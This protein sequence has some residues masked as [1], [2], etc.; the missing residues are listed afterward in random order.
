MIM[1]PII[2][3]NPAITYS[4]LSNRRGRYFSPMNDQTMEVN[5]AG[6]GDLEEHTTNQW[7]KLWL[8]WMSLLAVC[9]ACV[10]FAWVKFPENSHHLLKDT[11]IL[12]HAYRET[13]PYFPYDKNAI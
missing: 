12:R 6:D 10:A 9:S 5:E 1:T 2:V 3:S 4:T 8:I 11:D 13:F 7:G